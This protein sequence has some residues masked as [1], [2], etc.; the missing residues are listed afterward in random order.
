MNKKKSY[1][2]DKQVEEL[3]RIDS[4][5]KRPSLLMHVCCAVCSTAPLE[6]LTKHFEVSLFFNNSNIY[7][8]TEY[9]RRLQELYKYLQLRYPDIKVITVPY[10]HDEYMAELRPYSDCKEG[11][12]RCHICYE[13]R[14]RQAY[15]YAE[16]NNYDYFCTVMTIS[17]QKNSFVLN[18]IGEKLEK[19]FPKTKYFYSDFKKNGGQQRSIDLRKEYDLYQQDY[20]GCE[21]SFRNK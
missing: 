3:K 10:D 19:E 20:C 2:Y 1:Y 9:T 17:R 21:Y 6:I 14:M 16:E 15:K 4:L 18:E 11:Q 8:E 13:K 5:S 12:E 7:P